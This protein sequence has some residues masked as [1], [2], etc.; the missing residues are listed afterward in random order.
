MMSMA[1]KET[2]EL[3]EK[4]NASRK[5]KKRK[6]PP[7]KEQEE[8]KHFWQGASKQKVYRGVQN[9]NA[10]QQLLEFVSH[11]ENGQFQQKTHDFLAS[12]LNEPFIFNAPP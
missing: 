2:T 1:R 3:A 9:E 7:S 11:Y 12:E 5:S 10:V 8:P 6:R 4:N